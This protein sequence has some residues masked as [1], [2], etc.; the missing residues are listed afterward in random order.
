MI[1]DL[2]SGI[3]NHLKLNRIEDSFLDFFNK[4]IKETRSYE[5]SETFFQLRKEEERE[6]K[7]HFL[8]GER[9]TEEEMEIELILKVK[10]RGNK[11]TLIGYR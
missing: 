6:E 10:V 1:Q 5:L 4:I 11:I 9:I 8:N 2:A 7:G 3:R